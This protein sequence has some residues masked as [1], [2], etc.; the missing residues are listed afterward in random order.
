MATVTI[1]DAMTIFVGQKH[2]SDSVSL[3]F[4]LVLSPSR[5]K[6]DVEGTPILRSTTCRVVH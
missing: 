2:L 6:S 1:I 4:S 5:L 3:V